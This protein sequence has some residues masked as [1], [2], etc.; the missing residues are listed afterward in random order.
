MIYVFKA[1]GV[2]DTK[3]FGVFKNERLEN[4]RHC[5]TLPEAAR[6]Y[7]T[8][9][10]TARNCPTTARNCTTTARQLPDNCLTTAR[11]LPDTTLKY[12][13]RLIS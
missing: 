8:L 6:L 13:F 1:N 2:L 7:S 3:N 5:P 9:P 4:A 10:E 12:D 11:Q